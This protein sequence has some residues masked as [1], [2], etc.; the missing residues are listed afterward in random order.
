MH[1]F[2]Y[3]RRQFLIQLEAVWKH[4][5]K[6]QKEERLLYTKNLQNEDHFITQLYEDYYQ[7][8]NTKNKVKKHPLFHET[9]YKQKFILELQK[10]LRRLKS[11][12][13]AKQRTEKRLCF[14]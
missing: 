5:L 7:P 4:L 12:F 10:R 8:I 6:K 3:L 2:G 9:R 14:L 1:A 11:L 13:L